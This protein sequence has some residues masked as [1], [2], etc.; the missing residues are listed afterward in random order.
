MT[1]YLY[2]LLGGILIGL[3][4]TLLLLL[5]GRIA[6]ISGIVFGTIQ[7]SG[8]ERHWRWLFIVGLMTGALLFHYLTGQSYPQVNSNLL[9]AGIAGLLVGFGVRLGNG[10]TSGHGVC[11]IGRLS[12][13]STLA[14]LVFM[15]VGI[16]TVSVVNHLL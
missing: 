11:G 4:A 15:L 5:L 3:S 10:C 13:R 16:L 2:P 6:G 7:E 1:H 14:T 9:L 12:A 8:K